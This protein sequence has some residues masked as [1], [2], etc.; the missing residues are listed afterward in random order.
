MLEAG[1]GSPSDDAA[2]AMWYRRCISASPFGQH[3]DALNSLAKLLQRGVVKPQGNENAITLWKQAADEGGS[4]GAALNL[5]MHYDMDEK[6]DVE[7]Q[8]WYA[9]ASALGDTN[10]TNKVRA[11]ALKLAMHYDMDKQTDAEAQKWYA[12][13]SALGDTHAT[14]KLRSPWGVHAAVLTVSRFFGR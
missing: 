12:T 13:A 9:R 10:A 7:A 3:V 1:F 6:A 8:K 5:A 2:A 11:A 14:S 4:T